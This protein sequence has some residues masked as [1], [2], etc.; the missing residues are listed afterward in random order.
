MI[1]S[2]LNCFS[3]LLWAFVV[4]LLIVFVF[5]SP[6]LGVSLATARHFF[7]SEPFEEP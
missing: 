3:D 4:I 5:G 6:A 7:V 2:I 1:F